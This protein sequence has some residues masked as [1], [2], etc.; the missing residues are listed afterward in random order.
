MLRRL[1]T[2]WKR[3]STIEPGRRF[4]TV[5]REQRNRPAAVKAVFLAVAIGCFALGLVFVLIPGPAILFFALGG[6]LLATQFSWVA[7]AL[8]AT[9]IWGRNALDWTRRRWRRLGKGDWS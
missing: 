5:H 3:L 8:D 9:E 7:R 6:A 1:K 2:F 4:Q